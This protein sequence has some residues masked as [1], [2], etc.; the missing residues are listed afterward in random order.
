MSKNEDVPR[1]L[2]L[3]AADGLTLHALEWSREGTPLL[4]LH[5]YSNDAHVWDS[6]APALAS[7]Y[8][9][10]ALDMRGHGD[11]D[12][13]EDGRYDHLSMARDVEAVV[14]SLG[15]ER[16]VVVGFSMGG[17]VALRF[18]GRNP[19]KMAGLV[20]VDSGPDLD[21][22]GV[23]RISGE[24]QRADWSFAS[25]EE[26]EMVLARN[27]P[28]AKPKTLAS[29]A[30]TTTRQRPDGRYELKLDPQFGRGRAKWSA[31][32]AA[33]WSAKESAALWDALR[34]MPCPTLVVRGAASD[35]LS[36]DAAD[37]MEE[38]LP[39]GSLAVVPQAGHSVMIDNPDGFRATLV[40]FALGE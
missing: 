17:R 23:S 27:Y 32:E 4:F 39:K 6:A 31:E 1:S 29:I 15:I 13:D 19:E 37:A 10:L 18:A 24:M 38:A 14:A 11:S 40:S 21:E 2:R 5:G 36:A 8:R 35:V 25:I 16:L 9:T 3:S 7:H 30:R 33:E 26:Y 12:R 20:I 22:R 28:A 34:S